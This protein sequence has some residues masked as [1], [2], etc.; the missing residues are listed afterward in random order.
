MYSGLGATGK[1]QN[2]PSELCVCGFILF[3]QGFF[4]I[5]AGLVSEVEKGQPKLVKLHT[6]STNG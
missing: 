3:E 2:L 6:Q 1:G 4:V 5:I